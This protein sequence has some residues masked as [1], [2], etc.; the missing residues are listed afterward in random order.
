M[1]VRRD[2]EA[3]HSGLRM[4]EAEDRRPPG[5]DDGV[6]GHGT[7]GICLSTPPST[8]DIHRD[9]GDIHAF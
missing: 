8:Y 9:Y 1:L 5:A 7:G 6:M 4:N 2:N 3:R